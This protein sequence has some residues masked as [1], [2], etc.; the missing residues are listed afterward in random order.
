MPVADAPVK[1]QQRLPNAP[2]SRAL[3]VQMPGGDASPAP[4]LLALLLLPLLS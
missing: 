4:P 3:A 1:M 2:Q